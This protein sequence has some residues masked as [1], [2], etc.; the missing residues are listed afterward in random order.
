MEYQLFVDKLFELGRHEGFEAMEV[1]FQEDKKFESTVFQ[2]EVDKFSISE[3]AGLSF[4]GLYHEKMGYA[5]TEKLDEASI[6]M[7]VREAKS[8]AE[9]I[10]SDDKIDISE[11]KTGYQTVEAFYPDLAEVSKADKIA[12]LKAV[13]KEAKSLDARVQAVSY[14]LF[15]ES[16]SSVR[17]T[18]TKG[19]NLSDR[20]NIGIG[21]IS[22]LAVE[23][24]INK[25]GS[26]LIMTGDF[27]AF[28]YKKVAKDAVAHAV[29][30]FGAQSVPSKQYTVVF[31]N[32]CAAGLLAAFN[33]VFNA[34]VV[35]KD[36]SMM[37]GRL[38]DTVASACVTLVDDPFMNKGFGNA[39]FDAEGTPTEK[40]CIIE[41]GVLKTFLHN[42]K[43][44]L[45]DGVQSTGNASKASY[46]SSIN[47]APQ[48]LYIEPGDMSFEALIDEEEC[49]LITDLQG[50]HSGLNTIS[51]DF[52]LAANGFLVKDGK[53]VR[54]VDQIT[55]AG[56]LK[57]LLM[58][59]TAVGNDLRYAFPTGS[60]VYA[61]SFKVKSLSIAGD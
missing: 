6:E 17:I 45:K 13:E 5:F 11:P 24:G 27:K 19:L 31:E 4:R 25:S 50:M 47:I 43:T 48:N 42:N 36:L 46:K 16:E 30:Q 51:G 61:P 28:D 34:E 37:K 10:E 53:K 26:K 52:S 57:E 38:G 33:S 32:Q 8:N 14:N 12:F 22:I 58:D 56:N 9:V 35:Q 44:A 60:F 41:K 59:I 55:V 40:T 18:N 49:M 15:M 2:G 54:A 23:N 1:Y 39:S 20:Q 3:V 29:S 7:L 21:Y